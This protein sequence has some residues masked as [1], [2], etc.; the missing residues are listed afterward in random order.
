MIFSITFG[1]RSEAVHNGR[2]DPSTRSIAGTTSSGPRTRM[3]FV[4]GAFA[5]MML[6]KQLDQAVVSSVAGKF[7]VCDLHPLDDIFSKPILH[8]EFG[9]SKR[10]A[11]ITNCEKS[12]HYNAFRRVTYYSHF[13]DVLLQRHLRL[14]ATIPQASERTAVN[15]YLS[16]ST[17]LG[18]GLNRKSLPP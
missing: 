14:T 7:T 17:N 1:Q 15:D 4:R 16:H 6:R 3:I 13:R 5:R 8:E 12:S 2:L 11:R 18:R 10:P 9:W